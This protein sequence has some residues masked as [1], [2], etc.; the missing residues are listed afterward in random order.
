MET[1]RFSAVDTAHK[2]QTKYKLQYLDKVSIPGLPSIDLEFGTALHAGLN[3]LL[4]GE[5]GAEVFKVYWETLKGKDFVKA[6]KGWEELKE[7]GEVFLS[8]FSRL[9]AKHF[10]PFKMEERISGRI[11]G[12]NFEGTPDFVG[13][14][15]GIPSIVDFKTSGYAY[16]K[17]KIIV[18]EQMPLYAEL[19]KQAYKYDVKQLVYFVFIKAEMR[20]Q[21]VTVDLTKELLDGALKNVVLLCDE[22]VGKKVFTKNPHSCM[23]GSFKCPY[24]DTCH[25]G[26]DGR[27][28]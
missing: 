28:A 8:R 16:P 26:K 3:S 1:F 14:Y 27:K 6:R 11:G 23:M 25:G 17:E 9:H 19:V 24:F 22:L 10:K 4:E 18:N 21:V 13:D 20:I 5:D 12:H 15:K 7:T 2:C